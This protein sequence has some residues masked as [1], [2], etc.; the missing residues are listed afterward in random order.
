MPGGGTSVFGLRLATWRAKPRT[1]ASL[2]AHDALQSGG[3]VA[4]FTA[5]FVVMVTALRFSMKE[6]KSPSRCAWRWNLYPSPWRMFTYRSSVERRSVTAR[7]PARAGSKFEACRYQPWRRCGWCRH[8]GVPAAG[9][10][11]TT[12]HRTG[13]AQWRGYGEKDAPLGDPECRHARERSWRS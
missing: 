5:S 13:E 9:Q 8:P 1:A 6:T 3:N 7:L 12:S 2:N 4:H 11:P 10:S